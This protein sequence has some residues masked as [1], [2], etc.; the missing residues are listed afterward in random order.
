MSALADLHQISV[1]LDF[2]PWLR[3]RTRRAST[4]DDVIVGLEVCTE[5]LPNAGG[6]IARE[7]LIIRD[8]L[9]GI[10]VRSGVRGSVRGG[11]IDMLRGCLVDLCTLLNRSPS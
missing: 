9:A 11:D 5:T 4:I 6:Y 7:L 2:H 8:L 1:D 3:P 10:A